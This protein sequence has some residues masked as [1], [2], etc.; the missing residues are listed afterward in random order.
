MNRRSGNNKKI[1]KTFKDYLVPIFFVVVI[2]IFILNYI[3]GGDSTPVETTGDN[4]SLSLTLSSPQTEAYVEYTGGNKSKI[5]GDV[6]LYKSEK[7]QVA[8]ESVKLSEEGV[9]FHLNRLGELRFNEDKTF[10]LY[11][12]DLWGD[13]K[14]DINIEMRYAKVKAISGSVFSL[15]QNEVAST[16][17][18]VSGTIEVQNLAGASTVLKKGEKLVI[19]R[20]NANDKNADLALLKEVIDEYIKNEDWFLKNNGNFYLSQT[21][22]SNTQTGTTQTGSTQVSTG[23]GQQ[24]YITFNNLFDDAEVSADKTDIIGTIVDD[25]VAIININ[26]KSADVDTANKTFSIK[27]VS[28]SARVNDLV[29]KIYDSSSTLLYKGVMTL[30]NSKGSGNTTTSGGTPSGLAQVQNYPIASSPLYQILT[31]KQNPYTTTEN[32]VRIEGNVPARTVK[33]IVIND[34]QLQKFTA[35]STYWQYFANSEFGNLKPGVNI[36]KI[37]FYGEADTVVY[38]TNFTIIKEEEQTTPPSAQ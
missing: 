27:E 3:F 20:N 18:V 31:P 35:N 11:S 29:Y 1:L 38:E 14:K 34:F 7:L 5:E 32:V 8:S 13:T 21:E 2:F 28:T 16:I 17:Y 6:L 37:Q 25:R 4:S 22:E 9:T 10:T 15:S 36:Y 23:G 24:S 26:G 12:S 30:H 19:M 33:K